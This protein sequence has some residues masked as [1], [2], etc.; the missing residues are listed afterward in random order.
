MSHDADKLTRDLSILAAMSAEMDRYL[1][2][3]VLFWQMSAAGMPALTLGGFLMR[4]YRLLA[5]RDL[6]SSDQLTTLE[7][8]VT[9]YN[10]AIAERIVR[11]E[12]KAHREL[13]A[14]IRQWG[15]YLKDVDR[16]VA[17][18]K[19]NYTTVVEVRVMISAIMEQ[20]A[21]A[22]FALAERMPQQISLLDS[23][24]R[25][26]WKAGDFVWPAE[27]EPAYPPGE[28]WWLY[29]KPRDAKR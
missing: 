22:P 6:L 5:L 27:W 28:Y 11:L 3:E 21:L 14:R 25:R 17:T 10:Q 16:G 23:Q 15:E 20:L 26:Y 13:E 12:K 18:S 9:A 4:Q 29:G 19:S 2:S 8:A 24:L 1:D 7:S